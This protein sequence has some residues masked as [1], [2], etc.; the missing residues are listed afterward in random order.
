MRSYKTF[1][2]EELA[3]WQASVTKYM[4]EVH[5]TLSNI[6]K[7]EDAP[8]EFFNP[9]CELAKAIIIAR[10]AACNPMQYK[11]RQAIKII[12]GFLKPHMIITAKNGGEVDRNGAGKMNAGST[13]KNGGEVGRKGAGKV[14]AG[15]TAKNGGEVDNAGKGNASGVD[16]RGTHISEYLYMLNDEVKADTEKLP[17]LYLQQTAL[18]QSSEALAK[19]YED[20]EAD[21]N[22]ELMDIM[23]KESEPINRELVHVNQDIR[24]IYARVDECVEYYRKHG[25]V[26]P[27]DADAN[28]SGT[29]AEGADGTVKGNADASGTAGLPPIGKKP[30]E[31]TKAEIDAIADP[32]LQNKYKE[33]RIE[34][35]KKYLRRTDLAHTD[36]WRA[37][38]HL[39]AQELVDWYVKITDKIYATIE[40]AKA[41]GNS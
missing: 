6:E 24:A 33:I 26:K 19:T 17:D 12:G 1:T 11:T 5:P 30:A 31:C 8:K 40:M 34:A 20:A 13:A 16:E 27:V 15:S 14:N 37:Q 35:N 22:T 18:A 2:T 25:E 9:G 28:T 39:R 23:A 7:W 41:G 21:G 10:D 4:T 32:A 38:V 29:V 36:E 3:K